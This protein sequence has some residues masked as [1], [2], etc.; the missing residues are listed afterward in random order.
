MIEILNNDALYS[1]LFF[2]VVTIVYTVV[3]NFTIPDTNYTSS[4]S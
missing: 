2:V 4:T 3:N 1:F